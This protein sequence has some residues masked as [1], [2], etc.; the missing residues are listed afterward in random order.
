LR[1]SIILLN[2][3][4]CSAN[5]QGSDRKCRLATQATNLKNKISSMCK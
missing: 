4:I 2:R 5:K 1:I 3:M